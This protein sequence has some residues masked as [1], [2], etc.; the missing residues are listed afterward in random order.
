MADRFVLLLIRHLPTRGN[1]ERRYI[2]W[3]DESIIEWTHGHRC[4]ISTPIVFGSDLSRTQQSAAVYFP[5]ATF[6]TDPRWRECNFGVF[7]G[8][9][10]ADLEKN[11]DYRRWIDDPGGNPPPEGESLAQLKKRVLAVLKEMPNDAVVM[12]HGG[13]IR[14]LLTT[15]SQEEKAFW[16]WEIPHGSAYRLE[17]ENAMAFKEGKACTSISAVP[18][19]ANELT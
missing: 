8:K 13:P 14:V 19:T 15:F 17:W 5:E 11:E 2:G 4:L 3:T 10:Y 12:T 6:I 7:E 16:S 1:Q 18:I 9:T